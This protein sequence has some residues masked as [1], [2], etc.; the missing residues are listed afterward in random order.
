V[1]FGSTDGSNPG[2]CAATLVATNWA[3]TAA[4]CITEPGAT[5]KDSLSLVLGE[6]D[7]S[8]ATDS[9]DG[10]RKNV[11]L[12]LDPIVHE[13][14][15]SPKASSN[16]IAL[17]K[18]A[19]DI[20]LTTYTPACLPTSGADYTGQNGRVYGWGSTAS[21]P[22]ATSNI[23]LE[24]EVPIVSDTVCEAASSDSVTSSVNGQC[25]TE[26][27]S[28]SGVISSDM[29]CA[30]SSG[31]DACQ[32]DSGGPFTVKSSSTSQHDLVGVVSWGY[33]CAADGLYGVYAEVAQLRTWIDE[34]IAAN[35]GAT[36][37]S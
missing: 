12:A 6:F 24:V 23:L 31:K 32:G 1:N 20:D 2:N 15:Q 29:V 21:C 28:Y 27:R 7:L 30:G 16:D 10:K 11:Q 5:T 37:C 34:K 3:I 17:L 13:N 18:L 9:N 25:V 14:Y 36:F 26:A 35:G 19:E 4:H 8:S 22:A 33:G